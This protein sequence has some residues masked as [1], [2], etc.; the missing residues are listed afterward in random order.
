[1]NTRHIKRHEV[2]FSRHEILRA[3]GR[4]DRKTW[5]SSQAYICDFRWKRAKN[6]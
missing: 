5:R 4:I 3:D 1:V 6:V 2:D